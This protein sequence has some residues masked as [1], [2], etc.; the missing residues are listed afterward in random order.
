MKQQ[1]KMTETIQTLVA[2]GKFSKRLT[3]LTQDFTGM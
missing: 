3:L 1:K 2:F